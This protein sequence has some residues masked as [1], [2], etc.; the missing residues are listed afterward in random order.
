VTLTGD[1]REVESK[2]ILKPAFPEVEGNKSEVEFESLP[3][4]ASPASPRYSRI[5]TYD[6]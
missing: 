2:R 5:N 4:F 1:R 6:S 3:S